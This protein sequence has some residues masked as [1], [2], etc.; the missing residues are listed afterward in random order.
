MEKSNVKMK[1][2]MF[3]IFLTLFTL[4]VLCTLAMVFL[5]FGTPTE[6]E[7]DLLVKGL[8]GEVATCVV[9]LFYSIFGLK[10]EQNESGNQSQEINSLEVRLNELEQEIKVLKSNT[11]RNDISTLQANNKK[12]HLT[13]S[14]DNPIIQDTKL[15]FQEKIELLE[16]HSIAPPFLVS[17]YSLK[18][19]SVEILTEIDSSK[20]FN[21]EKI[22]SNFVG[23]KVQ[24]KCLFNGIQANSDNK[25]QVRCAQEE[26]M[27]MIYFEIDEKNATKFKIANENTPFWLCGEIEG[28]DSISIQL[29]D[30]KVNI[31]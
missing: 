30:V 27:P 3:W 8:I 25:F 2:V 26:L 16:N 31:V 18:P 7:R 17:D 22:S 9:A 24:W 28:I 10:S 5:G 12:N 29:K 11:K 23:L 14:N 21:K 13:N 4:S 1:W 15:P 6:S 20:P 19:T